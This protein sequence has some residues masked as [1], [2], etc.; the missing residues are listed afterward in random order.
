MSGQKIPVLKPLPSLCS[1]GYTAPC[2]ERRIGPSGE[3]LTLGTRREVCI[4]GGT[5]RP[6]WLSR[7][8]SCANNGHCSSFA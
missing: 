7:R 6:V 2:G 5:R 3:N 8:T 4:G 1:F